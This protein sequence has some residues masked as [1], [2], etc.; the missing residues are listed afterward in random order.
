MIRLILAAIVALAAC[1]GVAQLDRT[2]QMPEH[3]Q[4]YSS[5]FPPGIEE[6]RD[7][8]QI[9]ADR[10]NMA[11]IGGLI[12]VVVCCCLVAAILPGKPGAVFFGVVAGLVLGGLFGALGGLLSTEL[13]RYLLKNSIDPFFDGVLYQG[14]LTIAVACGLAATLMCTASKVVAKKLSVTLIV[15]AGISAVLYP[16][17]SA[18]W[19]PI[20]KSQQT[21]PEGVAN[22]AVWLGLPIL[23]W[24]IA[25]GRSKVPQ[26]PSVADEVSTT[27]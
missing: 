19:F 7:A 11:M 4:Q 6:Q 3:L 15:V 18:I 27:P 25:I 16:F 22:R 8:A 24:A 14:S 2:F 9:V 5:P 10:K 13:H 21:V 1:L 23:L 26:S 17:V 20:M 12:G